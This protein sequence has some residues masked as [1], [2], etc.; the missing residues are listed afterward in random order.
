MAEI[1]QYECKYKLSRADKENYRIIIMISSS[2]SPTYKFSKWLEE[3]C[4][5]LKE[6]KMNNQFLFLSS[7][8]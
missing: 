4:K 8:H 6:E 5:N 2:D 7:L 1:N 3:E